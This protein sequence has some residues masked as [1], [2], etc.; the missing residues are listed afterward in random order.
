[1]ATNI[2][3]V[4][5]L[6]SEAG[7]NEVVIRGRRRPVPPVLYHAT[8]PDY[9]MGNDLR[10]L[11]SRYGSDRAYRIFS[12]R[13]PDAACLAASHC[14]RIFFWSTYQ[15]AT[16]GERDTK[17]ILAIDSSQ[18]LDSLDYDTDEPPGYWV[19]LDDVPPSAIIGFIRKP[20]MR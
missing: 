19:S 20:P 12:Q 10:S 7:E 13:W 18:I 2:Q 6:I 5:R 17:R 14:Q 11:A 3:R 15:E 8:G 9:R 1:M 16:R 4:E